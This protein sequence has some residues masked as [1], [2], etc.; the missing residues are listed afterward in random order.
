MDSKLSRELAIS[1]QL[2]ENSEA[3]L[4]ESKNL[5]ERSHKILEESHRVLN[6][7]KRVTLSASWLLPSHL[8][9]IARE[10]DLSVEKT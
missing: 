8:D 2:I 4:A 9:E 5:V 7:A 6:E 3:I 1:R 10:P